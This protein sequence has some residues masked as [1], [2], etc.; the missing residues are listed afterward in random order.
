MSTDVDAPW[1]EPIVT[2]LTLGLYQLLSKK[3]KYKKKVK[4][5]SPEKTIEKEVTY[6][7][8][9]KAKEPDQSAND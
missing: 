4:K 3:R 1:W 6:E 9:N 2:I 7:T 8:E 5:I